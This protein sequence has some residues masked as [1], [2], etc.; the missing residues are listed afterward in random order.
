MT[1]RDAPMPLRF[2][3]DRVAQAVVVVSVL[4]A[5]VVSCATDEIV[6][7]VECGKRPGNM[8][9]TPDGRKL[10]V[11]NGRSDAVSVL[12]TESQRKL[13]DIPVG[14]LPWGVVIR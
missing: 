14:K 13:K 12:D 6:A 2:L 9:V 7:S 5:P 1:S 10:Y 3:R 11:A 4:S 8:A